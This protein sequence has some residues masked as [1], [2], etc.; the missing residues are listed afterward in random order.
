[1]SDA[2]TVEQALGILDGVKQMARR[3]QL[4]RT[5]YIGQG[6]DEKLRERGA[7]CGG[8]KACLI[9]SLFLAAGV[10]PTGNERVGYELHQA[11]PRSRSNSMARR[12]ALRLAYDALN[13]AAERSEAKLVKEFGDNWWGGHAIVQGRAENLF[14]N[15]L[16]RLPKA[17]TTKV[18]VLLCNQARRIVREG[19]AVAA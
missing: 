5:T 8:H 10:Q 12:P 13:L 1:V 16:D 15:T 6:V 18:V 14:E 2:A 4:I 7:I 9:G 19:A 17:E 3:E 11:E